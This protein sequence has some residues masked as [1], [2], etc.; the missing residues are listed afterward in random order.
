MEQ[1]TKTNKEQ[2]L[3]RPKPKAKDHNEHIQVRIAL[4]LLPFGRQNT[5]VCHSGNNSFIVGLTLAF[6]APHR[7]FSKAMRTAQCLSMCPPMDVL[8]VDGVYAVGAKCEA[9]SMMPRA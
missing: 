8:Y 6:V 1:S 4:G 3:R 7:F 9:L 5:L 2:S